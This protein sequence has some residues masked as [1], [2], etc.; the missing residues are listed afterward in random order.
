MADWGWRIYEFVEDGRSVIG[1]WLDAKGVSLRDRAQLVAKTDMLALHGPNLASSLISSSPIKSVRN[2]RMQSHVYKL[3]VRGD[4]MLR[5]F[6]CKGPFDMNS[7]FTF[8]L[9][10]IEMDGELDEDAEDAE[11]RRSILI[12]DPSRRILNGRYR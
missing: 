7:E 1:A 10:A 11:T 3:K 5:P 8:L 4:K 2:P 6:L 9:G 12:A